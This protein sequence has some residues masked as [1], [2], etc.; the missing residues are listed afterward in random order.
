M[1][2]IN[3]KR[4]FFVIFSFFL[5]SFFLFSSNV[6]ALVNEND[7]NFSWLTTNIYE[8]S[9]PSKFDASNT[10]NHTIYNNTD[11]YEHVNAFESFNYTNNDYFPNV[12]YAHGYY[13]LTFFNNSFYL[14]PQDFQVNNNVSIYDYNLTFMYNV[15]FDISSYDVKYVQDIINDGN[16]IYILAYKYYPHGIGYRA[17]NRIIKIDI[18]FNI[19]DASNFFSID[20]YWNNFEYYNGSIYFT[21][22][23][24]SASNYYIYQYDTSYDIFTYYDITAFIDYPTCIRHYEQYFYIN[25][26]ASS[27]VILFNDNFTVKVDEYSNAILFSNYYMMDLVYYIDDTYD[28]QVLNVLFEEEDYYPIIKYFPDYDGLFD[29]IDNMNMSVSQKS[30]IGYEFTSKG[31]NFENDTIGTNPDDWSV[32]GAGAIIYDDA[33]YFDLS[34]KVLATSGYISKTSFGSNSGYYAF[35]WKFD[36]ASNFHQC[37]IRDN[38]V[39]LIDI[40]VENTYIYYRN[41]GSTWVNTTYFTNSNAWHLFNITFDSTTSNYDGNSQYHFSLYYDSSKIVNNVNM[42]NPNHP[43]NLL[44]FQTG[45]TDME[46]DNMSFSFYSLSTQLHSIYNSWNF[47]N[48]NYANIISIE[49]KTGIYYINDV[50]VDF[51]VFNESYD[52]WILNIDVNQIHENGTLR[53]FD[54]LNALLYSQDFDTLIAGNIKYVKY[55]Q[56]YKNSEHYACISNLTIYSNNTMICGD[57][58]FLSYELELIDTNT[59]NFESNSLLS[60][61]G[62]GKYRFWISN[63]SYVN[64]TSIK[65]QITN[66]IVLN[67][68]V[69]TMNMGYLDYV[70]VNPYLIVETRNGM[71]LLSYININGSS[72]SWLLYDG[73]NVY[74]GVLSTLNINTSQ[75]YFYILSGKLYFDI[76]YDDDNL[77]YMKLIFDIDNFNSE[78]Y[79]LL[80]RTYKNES[81]TSII[82]QFNVKYSDASYTKIDFPYLYSSYIEIIE[83]DKLVSQIEILISDNDL[84][85]NKTVFGYVDGFTFNYS[86]QITISLFAEQMIIMLIPLIIILSMSFSICYVF[87]NKKNKEI[88]NKTMF[89][90][91]FF[92]ISILTFIFGFFDV[93]ILFI[94]IIVGIIYMLNK[95]E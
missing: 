75:S 70:I 13:A 74:N 87:R 19:I 5:I 6:V 58:G 37:D 3:I 30:Q 71:Y 54:N 82:N 27:N 17:Y 15:S 18:D 34:C 90:P 24:D 47:T 2:H 81:D 39:Y 55:I 26:G 83:Q 32:S 29:A 9:N 60:L 57:N 28:L 7:V 46:L 77:E 4:M 25:D 67:N 53:I 95:R 42:E 31:Y 11:Y 40:K 43:T 85:T 94:I 45:V 41:S 68:E 16:Y 78:N 50:A 12:I 76:T 91:V 1:K 69:F 22:W 35:Y 73:N 21:V 51:D 44:L 33:S 49:F 84:Q 10:L 36:N 20:Y 88:I 64:D 89:F 93:W 80:L 72:S 66:W 52:D 61:N 86:E 59:W 8:E 23:D 38:A 79:Q 56:Y 63:E 65:Y 92:I 14:F 48:E 62:Y